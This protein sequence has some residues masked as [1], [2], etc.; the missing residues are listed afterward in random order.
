MGVLHA[1]V[2][3]YEIVYNIPGLI[4]DD[5]IIFNPPRSPLGRSA[6]TSPR[7]HQPPRH[8]SRAPAHHQ[9]RLAS[10]LPLARPGRLLR[11]SFPV[12]GRVA[13]T[14]HAPSPPG[15]A[16]AGSTMPPRRCFRQGRCRRRHS[17][18]APAAAAAGAKRQRRGQGG[19]HILRAA[20]ARRRITA[21]T[22][23]AT[24]T[25]TTTTATATTTAA[26]IDIAGNSARGEGRGR[27]GGGRG[28][29]VGCRRRGTGTWLLLKR[30]RSFG[31]IPPPLFF[32]AAVR[33]TPSC[34]RTWCC[35]SRWRTRYRRRTNSSS[36]SAS[37]ITSSS[38]IAGFSLCRRRCRSTGSSTNSAAGTT[39]AASIVIRPFA[40]LFS[41]SG[42]RQRQQ[43]ALVPSVECRIRRQVGGQLL[44]T[45]CKAACKAARKAA[46]KAAS[47]VIGSL[48]RRVR[49]TR[50]RTGPSLVGQRNNRVIN[51]SFGPLHI[52]IYVA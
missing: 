10:P 26:E 31:L 9:Q 5:R 24:S 48:R 8:S 27:Q 2:D 12:D 1:P 20:P 45:R 4:F 7:P 35:R 19:A 40:T 13:A 6:R 23:A 39:T 36:A 44:K 11:L 42:G 34:I 43:P 21:T 16:A 38:A 29:R 25:T 51:I 52:Y 14:A 33:G 15:A 3:R 50:G 46:R 18:A 22:A 17:N 28:V 47:H 37:I 41:L 32:G 49:K 30:V